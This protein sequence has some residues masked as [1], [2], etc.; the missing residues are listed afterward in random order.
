MPSPPICIQ[1]HKQGYMW[2][3]HGN[4]HFGQFFIIITLT[5]FC[6]S[7][8]PA[9]HQVTK[10]NITSQPP[11]VHIIESNRFTCSYTTTR[12]TTAAAA[13]M[14]M[15]IMGTECV[16]KL[17]KINK[18]GGLLRWFSGTIVQGINFKLIASF[19]QHLSWNA[20]T[21]DDWTK[22]HPLQS[23][24]TT[25][26]PPPAAYVPQVIQGIYIK[27]FIQFAECTEAFRVH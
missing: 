23:E 1:A 20:H 24:F 21:T 17:R 7:L 12:T 18:A 27:L 13:A 4:P 26:P 8:P 3:R 6:L 10:L 16:I 15:M 9:L 11:D 2:L 14:M 25:P 22:N 19:V 5:R